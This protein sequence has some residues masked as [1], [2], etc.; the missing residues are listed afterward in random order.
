MNGHVEKIAC[1]HCGVLLDVPEGSSGR[2]ARCGKCKQRFQIPEFSEEAIA[3]L[4]S[5]FDEPAEDNNSHDHIDMASESEMEHDH[6]VPASAMSTIAAAVSQA[7]NA[8]LKILRVKANGVVVR[9]PAELLEDSLFRLS[10]PRTCMCCGARSHLL[11]YL[12]RFEP[13]TTE[14]VGLEFKNTSAPVVLKDRSLQSLEPTKL[15]EMLPPVPDA[16][17]LAKIPLPYW[18]CD[19]CRDPEA[20]LAQIRVNPETGQGTCWLYIRNPRRAEEFIRNAAGENVALFD[21]LHELN[22]AGQDNPWDLLPLTVQHRIEQWYRPDKDEHFLCYAP[23][24][25]HNRTEDGMAGLIVS[26]R[27][28]IY[29]THLQHREA[30]VGE[31]LELTLSMGSTVGHLKMKTAKWDVKRMP[32]DRDGVRTFRRALTLGKYGA[33]WK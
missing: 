17:G 5:E 20:V 7:G 16:T 9:F 31:H 11:A 32:I 18:L 33:Q 25:D 6:G 13:R 26:D 29:H 3:D 14:S 19:M 2:S 4:L 21:K 30:T 24:R 28:I 27:R 8:A 22:E 12:V 23:D 15:L 10:M 1:P